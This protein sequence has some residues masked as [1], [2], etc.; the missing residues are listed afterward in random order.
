MPTVPAAAPAPA[1]SPTPGVPAA[2]GGGGSGPAPVAVLWSRWLTLG[3]LVLFV[4][5]CGAV[6]F[7]ATGLYRRLD[8]RLA[9]RGEPPAPT[10]DA[11]GDE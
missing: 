4:L 2:T 8:L 6:A 1:P 10:V 9:F 7:S 5:G 3:W 11:P